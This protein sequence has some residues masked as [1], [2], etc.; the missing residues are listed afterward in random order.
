MNYISEISVYFN[1]LKETIDLVSKDNLN[2]LINILVTAK[3]A[4]K[5]IF[6]M[7]NGGSAAT[8]SH[9]VC[10]FNKGIS[11]YEEKKFKFIC[12]NDNIPSLMAYGNDLS[13]DDIFLYPLMTYFH[14]G[15]LVI[16]ISGSGNSKN[17]VKALEYAKDNNGVTIGLTGYDGGKVKMLSMYNV[18]IPVNDMQVTEDL[19]MILGHCIMK[20]LSA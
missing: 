15:D 4:G 3:D 1:R 7:G 19:H 17:V 14:P 10:D 20:I 12:L 18:Y 9:I 2:T 13:Y 11:L 16:G 6:I 5:Q 8:A